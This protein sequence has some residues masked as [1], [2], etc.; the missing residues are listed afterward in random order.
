MKSDTDN[1][2]YVVVRILIDR[3][4]MFTSFTR[5]E[6]MFEKSRYFIKKWDSNV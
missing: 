3:V 6:E 1:V 4:T 2:N 5:K